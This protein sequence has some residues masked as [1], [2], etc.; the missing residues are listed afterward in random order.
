[1]ELLR[2][3]VA[4]PLVLVKEGPGRAG[5][6]LEHRVVQVRV[7]AEAAVQAERGVLDGAVARGVA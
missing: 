1:M 4:L 5:L 3:P 6:V 2:R 7:E